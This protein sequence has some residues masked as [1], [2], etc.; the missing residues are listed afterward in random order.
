MAAPPNDPKSKPKPPFVI[1]TDENIKEV[2]EEDLKDALILQAGVPDAGPDQVTVPSERIEKSTELRPVDVILFYERR[3]QHP[4]DET[5]CNQWAFVV[6]ANR[7]LYV[8][9]YV[10][11][12]NLSEI[13]L[14]Q[15]ATVVRR[16]P[17]ALAIHVATLLLKYRWRPSMFQVAVNHL[18]ANNYRPFIEGY[19]FPSDVSYANDAEYEA[20]WQR[21]ISK[22]APPDAICTFDRTSIMST[23]IAWG[24]HG[25]FSH[26]GIYIGGGEIAEVVTSGTRIAPIETYKG[27]KFRVAVYRHYGKAANSVDEMIAEAKATAGQPGYDYRG[28]FLAGIKALFGQHHKT[29]APNSMI[30]WGFL[31]FITQV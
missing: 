17:E 12:I 19:F 16:I 30:L 21:M 18:Q 6:D 26:C 9:G 23:L 4:V 5:G 25:P 22:L 7:A 11:S 14:L 15:N 27:R 28:A 13:Y 31:T 20:A 3:S 24:T 1:L 10:R 8:R 2:T 29:A